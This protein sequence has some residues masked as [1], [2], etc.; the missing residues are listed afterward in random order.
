MSGYKYTM[1]MNAT[2]A[3][4][5]LGIRF[6][7]H[8]Y[9]FYRGRDLV[10]FYVFADGKIQLYHFPKNL[11]NHIHLEPMH[12]KTW[13]EGTTS[14]FACIL[15][16]MTEYRGEI[17]CH[18]DADTDVHRAFNMEFIGPFSTMFGVA[19]WQQ[20]PRWACDFWGGDKLEMY[21]KCC[22]CLVRQSM[23]EDRGIQAPIN[24]CT[25]TNW[26]FDTF[27]DSE[28]IE[29]RQFPFA[30]SCKGGLEEV[31]RNPDYDVKPILDKIAANVDQDFSIGNGHYVPLLRL[32]DEPSEAN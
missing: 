17:I 28:R 18:V 8:F 13:L 6:I 23:D 14:R 3:F 2:N 4:S 24:D 20:E 11:W 7:R 12:H 25:Y 19:H 30:T 10:E 22:C 16:G 31:V 29:R 27:G 21:R 5:V 15:S 9:H 26:Y 32:D 1:V